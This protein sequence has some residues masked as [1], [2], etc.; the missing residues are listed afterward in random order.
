[1]IDL[2]DDIVPEGYWLELSRIVANWSETP[3]APSE[4]ETEPLL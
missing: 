3:E 4:S 1:M 2:D